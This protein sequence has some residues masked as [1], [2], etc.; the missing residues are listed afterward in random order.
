MLSPTIAIANSQTYAHSRVVK[1]SR[2]NSGASIA[3]ATRSTPRPHTCLPPSSLRIRSDPLQV[4]AAEE[5]PGAD[6]EDDH[7]HG[8]GEGEAD[9][10]G[11]RYV[12][13][14][15][16]QQNAHSQAADDRSERALDAPQDGRRE[17]V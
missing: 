7:D 3:R 2:M 17:G 4:D 11:A 14:D 12:G 16:G 6:D 9:L 10:A 1:R 5:A 8:Q 15:Q 13:A